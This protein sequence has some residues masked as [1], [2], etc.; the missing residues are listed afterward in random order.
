MGGRL[1][2]ERWLPVVG[3]EGRYEVSDLGR[4]RSLLRGC[5]FLA[6][7]TKDRGHLQVTLRGEKRHHSV[8]RLVL[9]AF[10]G[11]C[12]AGMMCRH[13][14]GIPTDNRLENLRWGTAEENI[15]DMRL[16]GTTPRGERNGSAKLTENEVRDIRASPLTG[17]AVAAIYGVHAS[18][19]FRIREGNA[20]KHL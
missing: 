3:Y 17:R 12:P 1:T 11:P 7:H 8:H 13:L 15:A 18:R 6:P 9:A 2:T 10:V 20:W 5:H 19:V 14:N 4:V 16:H